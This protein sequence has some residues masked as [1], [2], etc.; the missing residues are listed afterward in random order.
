MKKSSFSRSAFFNPRAVIGFVLCSVGLVLALAG[1]SKSVTDSFGNPVLVTGMSGTTTPAQTPGTWTATGN[2][3]TA[4][5]AFTATLLLNGKVLVAGGLNSAGLSLASAE[6]Y[7]PSTGQWVTTGAMTTP[8]DSHRA[9][10]LPDGRVL[11]AGGETASCT[12]TATAE[13][14]DSVTGTWS[15]TASMNDPR[16]NS[17]AAVITAGPLAAAGRY[18]PRRGR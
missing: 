14:Y 18:G 16:S 15:G 7:D 10:L 12:P 11:V 4:R 1:W 13:L 3:N 17:L 9:M 6:L 2:M 8:R 5:H